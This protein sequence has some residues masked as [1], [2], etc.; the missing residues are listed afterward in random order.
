V[1]EHDLDIPHDTLTT[2][3]IRGSSRRWTWART[4]AD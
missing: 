1:P 3:A 4:I 2:S